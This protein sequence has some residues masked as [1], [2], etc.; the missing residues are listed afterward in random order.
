MTRTSAVLVALLPAPALA[1][2]ANDAV[3][4]RVPLYPLWAIIG[5]ILFATLLALLFGGGSRADA[6][7][8]VAARSRRR[9]ENPG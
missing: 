3:A 9:R 4:G 7:A 2:A 6:R 1:Q 8:R 5:V